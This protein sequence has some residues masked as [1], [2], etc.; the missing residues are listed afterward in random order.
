MQ[1]VWE[2]C[3]I[4]LKILWISLHHLILLFTKFL[5]SKIPYASS[6]L[7]LVRELSSS[8]LKWNGIV[9]NHDHRVLADILVGIGYDKMHLV[10]KLIHSL[11]F[12]KFLRNKVPYASSLLILI[13]FIP[14]NEVKW[15][16]TISW[17]SCFD[18]HSSILASDMIKCIW[19]KL[20]HSL[21]FSKFLWSKVPYASSLLI[22]IWKQVS[23]STMKWYGIV[24][25]HD[26]H[27]LT[28]I[29]V[30]RVLVFWLRIW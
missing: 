13:W 11:L 23:S 1:Y 18:W 12:S 17:S 3:C 22:L 10:A 29:L 21:L 30:C 20:I 27:V 15:D 8:T 14:N 2:I 25:Y 26:H 16:C 4:S 6:L 24:Q 7:I 5:W 19:W 28:D 9:R